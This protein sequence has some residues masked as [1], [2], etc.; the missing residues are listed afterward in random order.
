MRDKIENNI[1]FEDEHLLIVNKPAGV[2]VIPERVHT[3]KDS[4]Q[5]Q[6]EN[7]Y[8]KLYVVHRIDR[9]TSGLVC[10]AKTE[11]AHK[12]MSQMFEKHEVQK[13]YKA[14]VKGRM[15]EKQGKI[16]AP[17]AENPSHPGT[18]LVHP[19]GKASLTLYEVEEELRDISL[20]NVEI[21]TGRTHQIRV[22][23]SYIGH[24]LLVDK[25]YAKTEAF[26]LS[27][28]KRNYKAGEEG[29]QPLIDRLTLHAYRLVFKHPFTGETITC[30][31][32]FPR[33]INALLKV[34][35]KYG[36]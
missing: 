28:V 4:L 2:V 8:G 1:I 32:P 9:E 27:S 18:M 29:E 23:L 30:E 11:E 15:K 14:F 19:K 10:F 26:M 31:A 16:E 35:R 34:L 22:H 5:K 3:G 7:T 36:K 17:I 33:D 13:F 21:K 25:I 12:A 24:P 6:L 20:L